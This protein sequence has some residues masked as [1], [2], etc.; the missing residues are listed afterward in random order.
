[1][2]EKSYFRLQLYSTI[3]ET[4]K[5]LRRNTFYTPLQHWI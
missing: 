1:M 2:A 5:A 4:E 3:Q